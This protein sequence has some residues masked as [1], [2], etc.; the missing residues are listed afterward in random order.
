MA[1]PP[2]QRCQSRGGVLPS[3]TLRRLPELRCLAFGCLSLV[4]FAFV[5]FMPFF[6][7]VFVCVCG[8]LEGGEITCVF[9]SQHYLL[10][11]TYNSNKP[12]YWLLN[13]GFATSHVLNLALL[14]I[15]SEPQHLS[16]LPR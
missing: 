2:P 16:P 15:S 5:A 10:L 13:L 14:H 7:I 12:G 1:C 11:N 6:I 4:L 3:V 9:N 8:V